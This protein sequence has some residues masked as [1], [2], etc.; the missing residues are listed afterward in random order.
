MLHESFEHVKERDKS[1]SDTAAL[2]ASHGRLETFL[3]MS[4]RECGCDE[5]TS[6]YCSVWASKENSGHGPQRGLE[7]QQKQDQRHGYIACVFGTHTLINLAWK[8][9]PVLLFRTIHQIHLHI[10]FAH[11]EQETNGEKAL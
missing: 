9:F 8:C 7:E 3:S 5:C 6:G 10:I 4:M 2:S 1:I 11:D